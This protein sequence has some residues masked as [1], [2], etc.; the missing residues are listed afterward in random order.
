MHKLYLLILLAVAFAVLHA[1]NLSF[2]AMSR[3]LT[4][5][6]IVAGVVNRHTQSVKSKKDEV[7]R[8]DRKLDL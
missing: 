2:P 1:V 4:S 5:V 3:R 8:W 6:E 7:T